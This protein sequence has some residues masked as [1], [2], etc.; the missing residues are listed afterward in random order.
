MESKNN[1]TKQ[2]TS[3]V[4]KPTGKSKTV[5]SE[6]VDNANKVVENKL[7]GKVVELKSSKGKTEKTNT[8]VSAPT[9][10]PTPA[11]IS[12]QAAAQT[13][14][15]ALNAAFQEYIGSNHT[16]PTR[17]DQSADKSLEYFKASKTP[18]NDLNKTQAEK[19]QEAA[20]KLE[21][22]RGEANKAVTAARKTLSELNAV[23]AHLAKAEMAIEE[24]AKT[25]TPNTP[26]SQT[27]K[28]QGLQSLLDDLRDAKSSIGQATRAYQRALAIKTYVDKPEL[29][30]FVSQELGVDLARGDLDKV[31]IEL[32]KQL[33]NLDLEQLFRSSSSSQETSIQLSVGARTQTIKLNPRV[34]DAARAE[35]QAKLMALLLF[36]TCTTSRQELVQLRLNSSNNSTRSE[37]ISPTLTDTKHGLEKNHTIHT[38]SEIRDT[39]DFNRLSRADQRLV[40][41]QI[42]QLHLASREI[43]HLSDILTK[44]AGDSNAGNHLK[45]HLELN[46]CFQK[47]LAAELSV[48]SLGPSGNALNLPEIAARFNDK[49]NFDNPNLD[50]KCE[51]PVGGLKALADALAYGPLF[52]RYCGFNMQ[53][54]EYPLFALNPKRVADGNSESLRRDMIKQRLLEVAKIIEPNLIDGNQTMMSARKVAWVS[55]PTLAGKKKNEDFF[56]KYE[57]GQQVRAK[58]LMARLLFDGFQL[59]QT[60]RG[61][62]SAAQ[63]VPVY[64]RAA[65][66]FA[67]KRTDEMQFEKGPIV[68]DKMLQSDSSASGNSKRVLK[69]FRES[70]GAEGLPSRT[71]VDDDSNKNQVLGITE[72]IYQRYFNAKTQDGEWAWK[73]RLNQADLSAYQLHQL[74]TDALVA[75]H[76]H[77]CAA[78][79]GDV[80]ALLLLMEHWQRSISSAGNSQREPTENIL[81]MSDA[82]LSQSKAF[83]GNFIDKL[84]IKPRLYMAEL[85]QKGGQGEDALK[86]IELERSKLEWSVHAKRNKSGN[87]NPIGGDRLGAVTQADLELVSRSQLR[88]QMLLGTLPKPEVQI[89]P[90]QGSNNPANTSSQPQFVELQQGFDPEKLADLWVDLKFHSSDSAWQGLDPSAV[91]A[92]QSIMEDLEDVVFPDPV[93][94]GNTM[95]PSD[96]DRLARG[97]PDVES[98]KG[99]IALRVFQA[100]RALE[101]NSGPQLQNEILAK[102]AALTQALTEVL[103]PLVMPLRA[104]SRADKPLT[105]GVSGLDVKL[106]VPVV[107]VFLGRNKKVDNGF[108]NALLETKAVDK[109][110]IKVQKLWAD[111]AQIALQRAEQLL[112]HQP[113]SVGQDASLLLEHHDAAQRLAVSTDPAERERLINTLSKSESQ[114]LRD[115]AEQLRPISILEANLLSL[116]QLKAR[117]DVGNRGGELTGVASGLGL[118]SRKS[119]HNGLRSA[120]LFRPGQKTY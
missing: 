102:K 37:L 94:R 47:C 14:I 32:I 26:E 42:E 19:K 76:E 39:G 65:A 68:Q 48:G 31:T 103:G 53:A 10:A 116:I 115:F 82:E 61:R 27:L 46:G 11:P 34:D 21:Q 59:N 112:I 90:Q 92:L 9:P 100:M 16:D 99:T 6:H 101:H 50:K 22:A 7:Q 52:K 40:Y 117:M 2:S 85:V 1:K 74:A 57:V 64:A 89:K 13:E 5:T 97:E 56:E 70:L 84:V 12:V 108:Q 23:A 8:S 78:N 111:A 45:Y 20:E 77:V 119:A 58:V 36:K 18:D 63:S 83:L 15:N 104:R 55:E 67:Y 72:G 73:E 110:L 91:S 24:Y 71:S 105:V 51:G 69:S 54:M 35:E 118:V 62:H 28:N 38:L 87:N 79:S 30:N 49:L 4:E 95:G 43:M 86:A 66:S 81:P 109:A 60:G 120:Q 98:S 80:Q 114:P 41:R 93:S 17:A 113:L 106:K 88:L 107:G 25:P 44:S 96:S 33:Q 3:T 75:M 29:M